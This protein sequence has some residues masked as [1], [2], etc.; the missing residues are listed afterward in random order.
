MDGSE[1]NGGSA[2]FPLNGPLFRSHAQKDF[3]MK[4]VIVIQA[5]LGSSR[6]PC[7]TLLNLRGLPVI[8]W[9]VERCGLSKLADDLVVALPDTRRDEVLA[10]HLQARGVNIFRGSEQDVLSRMHGAAAAHGADVVVR[11]CADNPLI[12][13]GEIDNLI[14][15]YLRENAA[16]NCDYAYNHIPRNNLYPD[17]LGAE[18]ISFGLFTRALHEASLPA[19]REHCLSYIV[20]NPDL[21]KIR[22]FDPLDPALHHPELKLD[23]DTPDDFIN[24]S[25]LDIRPDITPREIVALFSQT[26]PS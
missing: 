14:R 19:H 23:M 20:D 15:F 5:R 10:R 1:T 4:T 12:W 8:D 22:T 2:A 17:G 24:L 13:G 6:L 21:F 11:V 18:I 25:L 3:A 9:V 26:L 7:K 16:G